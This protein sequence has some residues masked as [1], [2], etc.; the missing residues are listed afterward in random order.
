[1]SWQ[2]RFEEIITNKVFE[3]FIIFFIAASA[4]IEKQQRDN[5][6]SRP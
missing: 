2:S 1:M 6:G 4:L 3:F 5:P